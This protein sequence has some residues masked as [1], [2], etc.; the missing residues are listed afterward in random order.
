M[1]SR[2]GPSAAPLV[3][4]SRD[5]DGDLAGAAGAR[6][7][8]DVKWYERRL[9]T[10]ATAV[11]AATRIATATAPTTKTSTQ[12]PM[13]ST[14]NF[15]KPTWRIR[16]STAAVSAPARSHGRKASRNKITKTPDR[17]AATRTRAPGDRTRT[18]RR[19]PTDEPTPSDGSYRSAT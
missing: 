1:V 5:A 7:R 17:T 6:S 19:R 2:T 18:A 15:E 10:P 4:R 14:V 12:S 11:T 3:S 8:R 16:L 9:A 13:L